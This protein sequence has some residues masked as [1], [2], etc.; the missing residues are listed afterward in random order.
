MNGI[1]LIVVGI[2]ALLVGRRAGNL[3][4]NPIVWFVLSL[5][6]PL[7]S[8]IILE[9]SKVELNILSTQLNRLNENR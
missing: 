3:G 7:I 1:A 5:I 4:R 2:L 8:W 9:I 6:S